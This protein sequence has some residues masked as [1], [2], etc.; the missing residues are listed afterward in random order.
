MSA[1]D[2]S[3]SVVVGQ[4]NGVWGVKG[5]VKVYSYTEPVTRIFDYQPWQ[6]ADGRQL[7]LV[8]GQRQGNRLVAEIRGIDSPEQAARLIGQ[9]LSVPRSRLPSPE[10]GCFYWNDLAGLEVVNLQ[11]HRY[12]TVRRVFATGANDVLEIGGNNT[13]SILIPFVMNTYIKSV[14]LEK[15][16]ITVDWPLEWLEE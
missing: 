7:E 5:W 10:P 2:A 9:D 6:L 12:G 15:G 14:D 11:N 13:G 3:G 16:R 1:T 8:D 4:I